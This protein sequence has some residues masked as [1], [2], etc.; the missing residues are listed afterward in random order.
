MADRPAD[1][2]TERDG[3][4]PLTDLFFGMGAICLLAVL[5][6]LPSVGVAAVQERARLKSLAEVLALAEYRVD[7]AAADAILAGPDG[8]ALVDPA[9]A[10]SSAETVERIGADAIA[11][12]AGL[13]DRLARAR[14]EGRSVLLL[15]EPGGEDTAF[16]LEPVLAA[17][18]PQEIRQVRLDR[19]CSFAERPDLA[20]ACRTRR[21]GDREGRP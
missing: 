5:M 18:G 8:L 9:P 12:H 6:I 16:A 19:A 10:G 15:I 2:E 4:D 7:G 17:R 11:D 13:A 1:D 3:F 21:T 20:A 14:R